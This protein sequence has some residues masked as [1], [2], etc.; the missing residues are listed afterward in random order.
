MHTLG[1]RRYFLF[2]AWTGVS[3]CP[4]LPGELDSFS[5]SPP[6]SSP[7]GFP[8][9]DCRLSGRSMG[10]PLALAI[11]RWSFWSEVNRDGPN[12]DGSLRRRIPQPTLRWPRLTFSASLQ[13]D[14]QQPSP[15]HLVNPTYR[16][17]SVTSRRVSQVS[18]PSATKASRYCEMPSRSSTD[19]KAVMN[20][21]GTREGNS[22]FTSS[23][24]SWVSQD[25]P[26]AS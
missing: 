10:R 1:W 12:A 16:S 26:V 15:L 6:T 21:T 20:S 4:L 14:G 22:T 13:P 3:H 25:Q 5:A 7:V 24:P 23:S 2:P 8:G 19:A 9:G 18:K 11:S 17:S